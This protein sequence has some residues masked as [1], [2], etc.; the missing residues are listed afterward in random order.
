MWLDVPG[1]SQYLVKP[2]ARTISVIGSSMGGRASIERLVL[3]TPAHIE[4]PE[5][6]TG[7]KL[8]AAATG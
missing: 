1:A 6:I 5:R 3:L 4:S 2:G 7:P 8:F